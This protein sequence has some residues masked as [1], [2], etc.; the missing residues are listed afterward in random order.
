MPLPL[1]PLCGVESDDPEHSLSIAEFISISCT[2][3]DLSCSIKDHG[4]GPED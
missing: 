4:A 1:Q 2:P 3:L